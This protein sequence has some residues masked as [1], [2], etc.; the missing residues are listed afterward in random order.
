MNN[1]PYMLRHNQL[2]LL[3]LELELVLCIVDG[4]E[5][6]CAYMSLFNLK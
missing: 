6:C 5:L 4:S 1:L 3:T 2:N